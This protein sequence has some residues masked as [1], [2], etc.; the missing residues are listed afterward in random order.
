MRNW[1]QAKSRFWRSSGAALSTRSERLNDGAPELSEMAEFA[2]DGHIERGIYHAMAAFYAVLGKDNRGLT[3]SRD[4]G[5]DGTQR[6]I[7]D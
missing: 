5:F 1:R 4:T 7:G 2:G 3:R 6:A